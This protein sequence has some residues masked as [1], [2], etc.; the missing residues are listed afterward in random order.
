MQDPSR[1][2]YAPCVYVRMH[3]SIVGQSSCC[4]CGGL[5]LARVSAMHAYDIARFLQAPSKYIGVVLCIQ[6]AQSVSEFVLQ[7]SDELV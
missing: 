6:Q 2:T 7:F 5:M 1:H 3:A 4:M